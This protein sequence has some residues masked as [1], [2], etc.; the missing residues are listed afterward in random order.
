MVGGK[1]TAVVFDFFGV[2]CS[3]VAPRWL[4]SHCNRQRAEEVRERILRRVDKGEITQRAMFEALALI[5][6][7]AADAVESEWHSLAAL[8][9]EMLT[10]VVKLRS[11]FKIGLLTNASSPFIRSIL[12]RADIEKLFDCI[13][14]SSEC[15]FAKP[16]ESIYRFLLN[17]LSMRAS[18]V[19]FIDDTLE[20]ILA[21]RRL[22]MIGIHFQS[23]R[24]LERKWM[25]RFGTT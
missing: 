7:S 4:A 8:D 14:V 1:H 5:S 17:S 6:G 20:N 2:L 15:G 3:P 19:L 18:D 12:K 16:D 24:E 11:R 21:A 10:L 25:E 22:G 23:A 13:V 9:E